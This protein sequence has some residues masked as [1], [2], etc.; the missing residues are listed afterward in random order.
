LHGAAGAE[1]LEDTGLVF[2]DKPS[3]PGTSISNGSQELRGGKLYS[4][5]NALH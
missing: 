4:Q 1:A 3:L 2:L 5:K